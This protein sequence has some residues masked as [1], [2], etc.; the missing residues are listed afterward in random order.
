M[1]ATTAGHIPYYTLPCN[2][3]LTI[4]L[5]IYIDIIALGVGL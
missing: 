1:N 5:D 2:D 4:T 3:N